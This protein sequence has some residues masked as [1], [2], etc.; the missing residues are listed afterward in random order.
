VSS[1]ALA[2]NSMAVVGT[3]LLC[4]LAARADALVSSLGSGGSQRIFV[5]IPGRACS[6]SAPKSLNLQDSKPP[7]DAAYTL[8]STSLLS[9]LIE[10]EQHA[11]QTPKLPQLRNRYFALRHGQSESNL[12]GVISSDPTVGTT[13]HGLTVEGRLQARRAAT[14]LVDLVGRENLNQLYFYASDFTRAWQTA[15]E[16]RGALLNL[17][18]YEQD[19]CINDP[20]RTGEECALI[21]EIPAGLAVGVAQTPLLRER[22]FGALDALPLNNYQQVWPRDLVS[23]S[24][25]HNGV[26]SVDAVSA[27]IRECI[28][29]LEEKHKS[30]SIVLTSHADTLQIMQTLVANA[31]TRTF[32]MYRFMNGEVRELGATPESLPAPVPLTYL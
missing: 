27:R 16:A 9:T 29:S 18:E 26:E 2:P 19:V 8:I 30:C 15:E 10:V 5:H 24:H 4:W 1:V 32:S 22:W 6:M 20:A 11:P 23:A 13:I 3:L 25:E 12:E 14:R 31:D 7:T 17:L 21:A 28:L